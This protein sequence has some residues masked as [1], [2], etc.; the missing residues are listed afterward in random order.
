[1]KQNSIT[2]YGNGDALFL[3]SED[4]L[5]QGGDVGNDV[6]DDDAA[7]PVSPFPR[8]RVASPSGLA[9]RDR[10]LPTLVPEERLSLS[11]CPDFGNGLE[12]WL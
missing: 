7:H 8:P 9:E 4:D 2:S 5:E 1:M 12:C 11:S 10:P 6:V 3:S